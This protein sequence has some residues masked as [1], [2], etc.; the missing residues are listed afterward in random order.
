MLD[1][2]FLNTVTKYMSNTISHMGNPPQRCAML[3]MNKKSHDMRTLIATSHVRTRFMMSA[4]RKWRPP[5]LSTTWKVKSIQSSKT[6]INIYL[7]AIWWLPQD[8]VWQ[9]SHMG[10]AKMLEVIIAPFLSRK[11]PKEDKGPGIGAL[12]SSIFHVIKW[13]TWL[14]TALLLGPGTKNWMTHSWLPLE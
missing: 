11:K 13:D 10:A 12:S 9:T 5:W 2:E 8:N 14:Q 6:D 3:T 4:S 1:I 7:R